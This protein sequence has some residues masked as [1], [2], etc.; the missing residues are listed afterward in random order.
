[1]PGVCSQGTLMQVSA[2]RETWQ[3]WGEERWPC[4]LNKLDS[5]SHSQNNELTTDGGEI[6]PRG[7]DGRDGGH[8]KP[9]YPGQG[10]SVIAKKVTGRSRGF[11]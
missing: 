9:G 10:S 7:G 2:W 6:M 8:S 1:M 4:L 5:Q 3:S 11:F